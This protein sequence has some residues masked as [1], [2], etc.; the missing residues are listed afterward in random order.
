MNVLTVGLLCIALYFVALATWL[1][2]DRRREAEVVGDPVD[3]RSTPLVRD[4]DGDLR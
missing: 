2:L 3:A 1:S 4:E